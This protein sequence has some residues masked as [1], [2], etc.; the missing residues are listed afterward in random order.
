MTVLI[1]P[2]SAFRGLG[3]VIFLTTHKLKNGDKLPDENAYQVT[4]NL[5]D[6]YEPGQ[7]GDKITL[8]TNHPTRK[9]LEL[10]AIIDEMRALTQKLIFTV[11]RKSKSL[12]P[13]KHPKTNLS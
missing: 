3:Q 7:Y 1:T 9:Q 11:P 5:E 6:R 12:T 2:L 10:S 13:V 4:A 8:E